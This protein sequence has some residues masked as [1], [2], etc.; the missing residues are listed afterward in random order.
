MMGKGSLPPDRIMRTGTKQ[1]K[2]ASL[3]KAY[4]KLAAKYMLMALTMAGLILVILKAEPTMIFVACGV[5]CLA[6]IILN[7][8]K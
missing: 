6:L 5:L 8:V 7:K 3:K 1:E 2:E 4:S